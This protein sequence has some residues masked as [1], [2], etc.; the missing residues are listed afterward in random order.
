MRL[1]EENRWGCSRDKDGKRMM[2]GNREAQDGKQ[3]SSV[4]FMAYN[5]RC[6]KLKVYYYYYL[7]I[8]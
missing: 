1:E 7:V 5:N 2:V 4:V 3:N 8:A 6:I